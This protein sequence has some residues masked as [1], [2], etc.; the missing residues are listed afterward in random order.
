[1]VNENEVAKLAVHY[2]VDLEDFT[3]DLCR[4]LDS[5]ILPKLRTD[6]LFESYHN[7][8]NLLSLFQENISNITF[9]CTGVMADR[10]PD[11]IKLIVSD[12][13][14]IA[15]HGNFHDD[16]YGMTTKEVR[17]SLSEAK[18]KLSNISGMEIKG[19]RAPKFS[20]NK[21]D[22]A[23]LQAISE[24][25]EYD[26]SLHF[27]SKQ[28]YQSW[29]NNCTV[30]IKEFPVPYQSIISSKFMIKTGG[31]YLKLFP[32]SV[33]R[34]AIHK[35]IKNNITPIIYF[36]PYDLYY[37]YDML[38]SWNELKG[39]SS[40]LYWYIR[41][42]QWAGAFNWSQKNKLKSIFKEFKNL[43]RLDKRLLNKH[44]HL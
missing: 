3:Y 20:I 34:T 43:G 30:D 18:D 4:S 1:M 9:F 41:Q 10:Y 19:F 14:E 2:T 11:L 28:D 40:K 39:A 37:G 5:N 27:Q 16:I 8:L 24:V 7:I 26:S 13:H 23:R 32:K 17:D 25:F 29:R 36:H 6:S 15:C 38:A 44:N 12:G 31:S 33:V 21:N 35:T 42:T 22:Y